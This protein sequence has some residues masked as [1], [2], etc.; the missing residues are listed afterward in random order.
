MK[1]RLELNNLTQ[2]PVSKNMLFAIATE[3]LRQ[4]NY[5]FLFSRNISLSVACVAPEEIRALNRQY[6]GYDEVTDVLSFSEYENPRELKKETRGEIF[7]GELILCY[8]DIAVYAKK[9]KK[10]T[11]REFAV[12]VAHGMLHLLGM[13]H[14]ARMFQLQN[15]IIKSV[16]SL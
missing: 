9:N 4:I 16:F 11:A 12:V 2:S 13:K 8:D 1:L 6:R 5:E 3:A 14:S 7:L 15:N 10:D